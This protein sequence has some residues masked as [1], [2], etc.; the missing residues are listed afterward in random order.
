MP[1][2]HDRARAREICLFSIAHQ[3]LDIKDESDW[4]FYKNNSIEFITMVNEIYKVF[5]C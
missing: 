2:N 5:E 3:Q 4:T 1:G